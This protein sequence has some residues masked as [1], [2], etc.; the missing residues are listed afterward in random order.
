MF[1]FFDNLSQVFR[2]IIAFRMVKS[3]SF[4]YWGTRYIKCSRIWTKRETKWMDGSWHNAFSG[5]SLRSRSKRDMTGIIMW[6]YCNDW[7]WLNLKLS[8]WRVSWSWDAQSSFFL[9]LF[10]IVRENNT[11]QRKTSST[12]CLILVLSSRAFVRTYFTVPLMI[13][14]SHWISPLLVDI[15]RTQNPGNKKLFLPSEF[16]NKPKS[17]CFELR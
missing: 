6:S 12:C 15:A 5:F 13:K 11:A 3:F 16:K 14:C 1:K 8:W 17:C 9:P 10:K 2:I 4:D 7:S